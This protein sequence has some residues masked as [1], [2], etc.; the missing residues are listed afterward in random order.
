MPGGQSLALVILGPRA[1]Q[2]GREGLGLES[3]SVGLS[4]ELVKN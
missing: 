2:L 3:L 4:V 1:D